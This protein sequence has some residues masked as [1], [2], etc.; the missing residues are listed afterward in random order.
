MTGPRFLASSALRLAAA[1]ALI[2]GLGGALMFGA[3]Q[4]AVTGYANNS[5]EDDLRVET[6]VLLADGAASD[7]V[8]LQRRVSARTRIA[9]PFA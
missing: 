9:S 4:W 8:G 5:L 7:L 3:F 1:F 6:R 2:F